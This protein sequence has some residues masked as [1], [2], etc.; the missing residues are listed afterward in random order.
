MGSLGSLSPMP[1]FFSISACEPFLA[2]ALSIIS[3]L[4]V[5]SFGAAKPRLLRRTAAKTGN[6]LTVDVSMDYLRK[7]GFLALTGNSSLY[8]RFLAAQKV[9]GSISLF[10]HE[11]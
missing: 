4:Y 10:S 1:S 7:C 5:L 8:P 9:T 11:R 2:H 6:R 3:P